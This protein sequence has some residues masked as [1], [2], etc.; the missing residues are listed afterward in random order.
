MLS[1]KLLR[2]IR[3]TLILLFFYSSLSAQDTLINLQNNTEIQQQLENITE[4][5]QGEDTDFS[6]LLATLVNNHKRP[7]NLN[8]TNKEELQSLK[9]LTDSQINNLLQYLKQNGKLIAIFELQAI[10]GFDLKTIT[11]ILPYVKIYEERIPVIF[12][13][14]DFVKNSKNTLTFRYAQV[15][16]KQIGFTNIDSLSLYKNS[17]ARYIGSPQKLYAAYRFTDNEHVRFGITAE[18]DQGEL[19]LK[20]K[21]QFTY[22]WYEQSLKNNQK[23]G[24]DFYSAHLFVSNLKFIKALTIGD[25][26]ATFGQGLVLWN[27]FS[28]GK[29]LSTLYIKKSSGGIQP[30]TSVNENN[31]LRGAAT[32]IAVNKIEATVFYSRKQI[33]AQFADTL[34]AGEDREVSSLKETGYHSTI[35]EINSK[36]ALLESCYGGNVAYNT[37]NF[38]LGITGLNYELEHPLK[39][40]LSYYNQFEFSSKSN[41]NG[42]IDYHFMLHNFNFFGEAAK[43]KVGGMAFLNGILV[44]MDTR[45]SLLILHRYYQRNYQAIFG[46]GFSERSSNANEKGVYTG[47]TINPISTITL[48]AYYDRFEFP[49]LTYQANAPAYGNEYSAQVNYTPTKIFNCYFQIKQRN[50]QKDTKENVVIDH[51]VAVKQTNYR[52][53]ISYRILNAIQ[54]KNRIEFINYR[55]DNRAMQNGFLIY[56]EVTYQKISNPLS[57]TLRYSLFDTD[58]Y[59]TRLYAYESDMPGTYSIPS[60]FNRGSRFYILLNYNIS[61]HIEFWVRYSQTYYDN[62]NVISEGTLNE[63]RGNTKSEVKAQVQFKF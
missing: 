34:I 36:N 28:F 1:F 50:H 17:N 40:K 46:N 23:N 58:D 56:Q 41:F 32:T 49:W 26:Q 2:P 53:N 19:F 43:S 13:K 15:L 9:L 5:I 35:N 8:N 33:D 42:S 14:H 22:D 51:L 18:K 39:R 55:F 11:A 47:V 20:N 45:L 63:I 54:L 57:I 31:F 52:F 7:I 21:Q 10:D 27:G 16:E 12:N 38:H 29:S 61:R 48:N 62:K 4:S 6:G 37:A 59:D 30:Y 44:G 25:Y 60:Y 3:S 24:F